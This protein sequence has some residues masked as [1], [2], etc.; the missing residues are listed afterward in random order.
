MSTAPPSS[1][2]TTI[3]P[4]QHKIVPGFVDL[5]VNGYKGCDFSDPTLT[6]DSFLN[7]SVQ[8]LRD[9]ACVAF[10]PTLITSPLATYEHN[11]PIIADAI[12]TWTNPGILGI[13][14]EGPFISKE[15][16]AVG[17]H[18]PEHT[19]LPSVELLQQWQELAR[20]KIVLITIAAELKGSAE[21]CR[22]ATNNGIAVSLGHQLASAQDVTNLVDCGATLCTHLG[23]GMPNMIHRHQNPI[24]TSLAEDR[25]TVMLITDG[26]HLPPDAVVSMVRAKGVDGVVVTSDAAPVAGLPDGS[27]QWGTTPVR[28]CQGGVRHGTLECLAGSGSL[29]LQCMNMLA[30]LRTSKH[31]WLLTSDELVQV[32]CYNPLSVLPGVSH[33]IKEWVKENSTVQFD[34]EQRLFL[35]RQ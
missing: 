29:M 24:W 25:L 19:R 1:T 6:L 7:T 27:Y 20:G 23:N 8:I 15:P 4:P 26:E 28:V 30:G 35:V 2:S 5:Q 31:G 34:E 10:V 21:L 13:H 11:L 14:L 22:W 12:D 3:V 33:A 9:G 32:G 18:P 17:C 16:G